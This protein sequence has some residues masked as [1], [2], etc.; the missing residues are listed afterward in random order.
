MKNAHSATGG[1]YDPSKVTKR[2]KAA[3]KRAEVRSVRF[4]DLRHTFGVMMAQAGA[5]LR[6]LQAWMGHSSITTTERYAQYVPD[7]SRA[8]EWATQAF[9]T[10][11]PADPVGAPI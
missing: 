9:G 10:G 6:E 3:L 1:V 4:H 11:K 5:P 8:R 7:H 2:F